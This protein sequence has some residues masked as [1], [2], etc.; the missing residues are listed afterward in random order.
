MCK[1][2]PFTNSKNLIYL[3]IKKTLRNLSFILVILITSCDK[4]EIEINQLDIEQPENT[5]T[6]TCSFDS[7]D[8]TANST[9][10]I[11]CILNLNGE[12]ITLPKN[13]NFDFD[14][15]DIIN[16]TLIFDG[17][18][19]DGRLLSSKLTLEGQAKLKSPDFRFYTIR[20]DI[21]EGKVSDEIALKNREHI[22]K[23]IELVKKLEGNVFELGKLDVYFNVEANKLNRKYM[24]DRAIRI[25]SDIHFKMNND[26]FLRVQPT[27]FPIYY[28]ISVYLTD[29][30]KISGGNLIGDR[31]EHDY[32]PINDTVGVDRSE[33]GWGFLMGVIGSHDAIIDGVKLNNATGDAI[34]VSH[35]LI[36]NPDGTLTDGNRTSENVVI[37]NCVI[38]EARRNGMA[39]TD[40]N[41]VIIDNCQFIDTGKGD[42]AYDT[43]G[44]EIFSS[45]G[46]LPKYGIDLEPSR[47]IDA[48]GAL[49]EYQRVENI[50]IRNSK[51]TGNEFGDIVN[52]VAS[53]VL[54]EN[55][56]FDKWVAGGTSNHVTIKNNTFE[57]R[58]PVD[59]SGIFAIIITSNVKRGEELVHDFIVSG[60]EISGYSVAI[61]VSGDNQEILNNTITNCAS[62]I[63]FGGLSNSLIKDNIIN[64]DLPIASFG[65]RTRDAVAQNIMIEGGSV[66]VTNRPINIQGLNQEITDSTIEVTFNN[67]DL[68]TSSTN[69]SNYI[70][71]GE[72]ILFRD[73]RSNTRLE[74]DGSTD[75]IIVENSTFEN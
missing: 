40:A 51:F 63:S 42:Q 36:R 31:Y 21:T 69:F 14:G 38:K 1:P 70:N 65:Y 45:S 58:F 26:T 66:N 25:P 18:I 34:I 12:T 72:N 17:G 64:C 19:I 23:V 39:I 59:Q 29:N 10:N 22:N 62:G 15:G 28:L 32:T 54:I 74:K 7:L 20:W 55:N 24:T 2:C 67:I 46:A 41:G 13:V 43:G 16:G 33:H 8:I 47:V 48:D 56:F 71:N 52:H 68:N 30:T 44:N 57:S 75:N 11:D 61:S 27:R 4:D 50:T 9:I 53:N 35:K 5:A 6:E 3:N 37:K 60:N 73:C 49:L